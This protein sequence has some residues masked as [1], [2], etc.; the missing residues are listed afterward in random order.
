[1]DV[2]LGEA[3]ENLRVMQRKLAETAGQGAVKALL[4]FEVQGRTD[5]KDHD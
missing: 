4:M 3:G 1:M 2:R 5:R